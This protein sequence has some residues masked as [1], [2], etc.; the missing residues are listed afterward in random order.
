M[1]ADDGDFWSLKCTNVAGIWVKYVFFF[2]T[3]YQWESV[4]KSLND[5][6]LLAECS[7]KE[8]NLFSS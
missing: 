4:T 6:E 1:F 5:L 8:D 7:G 2:L 3:N